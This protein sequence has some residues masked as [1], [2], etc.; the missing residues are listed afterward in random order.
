VD[1]VERAEHFTV[2]GKLADRSFRRSGQVVLLTGPVASG[3]TTLLH[4][5]GE[6]L[7][8]SGVLVL[9]AAC[10]QA[11]RL[12]PCGVIGQL[13]Q[14]AP[15]PPDPAEQVRQLLATVTSATG[16]GDAGSALLQRGNDLCLPLL[17]LAADQP[18][19]LAVD[20]LQH[21]DEASL[22]VL[23]L[24]IR[25][26]R[27]VNALAVLTDERD[28]RQPHS[29]FHAELYRQPHL[30][31]IRVAPLSPAGVTELAARRLGE[32]AAGPLAREL[33]ATTGGN[34]LL[35]NALLNDHQTVAAATGTDPAAGTATGTDPAETAAPPPPAAPEYCLALL[36]CLHRSAPFQRQVAHALAVLPD[37]STPELVAR[38][39]DSD[40]DT[41]TAA[42]QAMTAAGIATGSG[43]FRHP[44]ARAALLADIP[45]GERARLH[46]RAA[47]QLHQ[48]GSPP[49]TVAEH[50]RAA[51]Q[52]PP[53]WAVHVLLAAAEQAVAEGP[54]QP[55]ASYLEQALQAD[56]PPDTAAVIRARL[57]ALEW[58]ASPATAERH[59]PALTSAAS[60]G[61]L[62][63]PDAVA[64][65]RQLLWHGHTDLA[66]VV[67]EHL[68]AGDGARDATAAGAL[69][70]VERWLAL[71]HPPLSRRRHTSSSEPAAAASP[72]DPWLQATGALADQLTRGASGAV[73]DRAE[74]VLRDL[75]LGRRTSW[76][77]E[78]LLT[79]VLVLG[80]RDR[81]DLVADWYARLAAAAKATDGGAP[82]TWQAILAT[83]QAE[84]A[85]GQGDLVVAK[86]RV[87]AA[88]AE[89]PPK[90]WG[91][92]VGW[93]VAS[94][95][96]AD[97]RLGNLDEA[98]ASLAQPL[99]PAMLQSRYGLRYLYAR[100][101]YNLVT[102]H[103]HAALADFL[104]CGDLVRSWG[105]DL[106]DLLP[107]RV[108]AAEAWLRL[109]NQDQARR[110]I[111]EQ[112]A[113]QH[114]SA[115]Q[116]GMSLR[117]L[118]AAG[119]VRRRPQLL[120]ESLELF[121]GL[122]D[123]YE[124]VRVLADLSSAYHALD[125]TRR[126]RMVFRR[127]LHLAQV[128]QARPLQQELLSVNGELASSFTDGCGPGQL[129]AL[130]GSERRVA[131]LAAIG[132]T[133][134][135]IAGKLYITASTVEQHLTR[136][137]RKLNIKRRGELPIDLSRRPGPR[138]A[139]NR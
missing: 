123:L 131:S 132:Y 106:S 52:P 122:G 96:L 22:Q 1:L 10:A 58:W 83:A 79:T 2:L 62:P 15:L 93:P 28:P 130:T 39:L 82:C 44:A 73:I 24:L 113:R 89:L 88:F 49:G 78:A 9:S 116:R 76:A 4:S 23:L 61:Q 31:R 32:R 17:R 68:R 19:L 43:R 80:C 11:E 110:L 109:G 63:R 133:N 104:S 117:L 107:W 92:V 38:L 18:V 86:E 120:A 101:H 30:H 50:L 46:G 74:Q 37:G 45:A 66:G 134:R 5:F 91:V 51:G 102:R 125:D 121:E 97:T 119:P 7:A 139:L 81:L 70:Q 16:T 94:L 69:H 13:L 25:R 129:S 85:L 72:V 14:G 21:A 126:A 56:P 64:L 35:L 95:V 124:Q 3:K 57:A 12:L 27:S 54:A 33:S 47:R 59:L 137:Y 111:S 8:Q 26:L 42:V 29:P 105:L 128:C 48:A 41:V 114:S 118:A 84:V 65:V 75:L 6:Q 138:V 108:C 71:T 34:P 136:V 36:S 115:R 100:G 55:A 103:H 77:D 112:M 67:L 60:A 135:E 98:A 53:A 90:A 127:A 99:P 87:Q 20:D 40:T